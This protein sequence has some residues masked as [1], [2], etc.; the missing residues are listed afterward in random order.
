MFQNSLD[1]VKRYLFLK[2]FNFPLHPYNAHLLCGSLVTDL[3]NIWKYA[4]TIVLLNPCVSTLFSLGQ[5]FSC[6][7]VGKHY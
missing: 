7:I 3:Q 1:V 2:N 4:S 5:N 6:G